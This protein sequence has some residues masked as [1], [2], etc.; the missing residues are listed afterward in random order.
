VL[1]AQNVLVLAGSKEQLDSYDR[2]YGVD[3]PGRAPVVIVGGGRVGRAAARALAT[4]DIPYRIVEQLPE[5]IRDT[6]TYV[7][8]DA[9]EREVL[10]AAGLNDARSVMITTHD[11]DVN[12]YLTIYCRRLRPDIQI[13]ARACAERNFSTLHRAG[14]DAVLS[15]AS[16]GA[17]AIWN[18]LSSD[19]TLQ[20]AE[21]LDVFRVRVPSTLAGHT[22]EEAR[23][24]ERTGC[25]VVGIVRDG[26]LEPSPDAHVPI[27]SDAELILI[28][29]TE[30]ELTFLNTYAFRERGRRR[31]RR[32]T[33]RDA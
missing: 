24:R 33:P 19:N 4:A 9:A 6:E 29:E 5:R 7:L 2:A 18:V 20:L 12:V 26:R 27:P 32:L 11:D 3:D 28:G 25:T 13:I 14:A 15:Y 21:G 8:G 10:D 31:K 22:M 23:L 16:T 17:N 30:A 1:H